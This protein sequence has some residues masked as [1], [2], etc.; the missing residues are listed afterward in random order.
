MT[1]GKLGNGTVI[2]YNFT[3][4]QLS[5]KEQMKRLS[6]SSSIHSQ[7]FCHFIFTIGIQDFY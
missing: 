5:L 3:C 1:S 7:G 4:L 6:I 2:M